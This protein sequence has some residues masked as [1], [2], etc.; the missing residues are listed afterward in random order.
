MKKAKWNEEMKWCISQ[1]THATA[2]VGG[3]GGRAAY[4]V[5]LVVRLLG[6]RVPIPLGTWLFVFVLCCAVSVK[7]LRRANHSSK[8]TYNVSNKIIDTSKKRP[9][10]DPRWSAIGK[11]EVLTRTNLPTF[12][13]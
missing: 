4:S 6:S 10:P 12:P 7:S 9:W 8:G 5:G 1:V 3:P 13:T 11:Q 2:I